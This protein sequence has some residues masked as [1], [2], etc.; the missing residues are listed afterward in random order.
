[1]LDFSI[2]SVDLATG[3]VSCALGFPE[4]LFYEILSSKTGMQ[5]NNDGQLLELLTELS[6]IKSEYEK[7]ADALACVNATGYGIVMPRPE[8][9]ELERPELLKKGS[10]V[11]V[12]LRA[13]AP[14]IH[15]IRVDIDTEISPMVGDEKQSQDLIQFLNGESPETLWQSNIFGKSVYDLIQ[16]GLNA[17]LVQTPTDVQGKF[18][19]ILTRIVNDGANGLICLI[20]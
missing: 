1:M 10:A 18:R 8:Q 9:M 14:S 20:L 12:K 4:A 19:G 7:I 13:A 6:K 11:G 16:E 15:M 2:R 17:K 3:T 5:I